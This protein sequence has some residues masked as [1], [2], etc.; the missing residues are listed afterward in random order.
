MS[1]HL[2][3]SVKLMLVNIVKG[4]THNSSSLLQIIISGKRNVQD[5]EIRKQRQATSHT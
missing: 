5:I 4:V 3:G 2:N 1:L